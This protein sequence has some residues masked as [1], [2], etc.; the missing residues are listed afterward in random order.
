MHVTHDPHASHTAVT[1]L[2]RAASS[3]L[4]HMRCIALALIQHLRQSLQPP[5]AAFQAGFHSVPSLVPLH[6][7]VMS[8]D[9]DRCAHVLAHAV[10]MHIFFEPLYWCMAT[11]VVTRVVCS[12]SLKK[13][14]VRCTPASTFAPTRALMSLVRSTTHTQITNIAFIAALQFLPGSAPAEL[15]APL[16]AAL[17][18]LSVLAGSLFH[19]GGG[20]SCRCRRCHRPG[21]H[22]TH[23]Q[24][25]NVRM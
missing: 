18:P 12:P 20:R 7:H 14:L 13:K 22:G 5:V 21:C 19:F 4:L 17:A 16:H 9:F 6:M 15:R 23:A 2:P 8:R 3:L 11:V 1:H 24:G 25:C 10:A